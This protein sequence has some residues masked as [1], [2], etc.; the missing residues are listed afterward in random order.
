MDMSTRR[1]LGEADISASLYFWWLAFLRCSRDYWWC[2]QQKG[3]CQDI[4]LVRVWQDFGDIFKYRCFM[5]WWQEHGSKLFDS[6]QMELNLVKHL[7]SGLELLV[8]ADLIRVRPDMVCI[9][10][11]LYLDNEVARAAIW[12]AWEAARV[13]GK[14][15]DKDA[16]YQIFKLDLKGRRTIV[17]AY[18]AWALNSLV[19]RSAGLDALNH[20]GSFEMGRHLNL[21]P[22]NQIRDKDSLED[23][24]RKQNLLRTMF[25]QSKKAAADLIANAEIGQFPCKNQVTKRTRWSQSQENDLAR[26][27]AEGQWQAP[28]WLDGE[29][30]FMLPNG[31][32]RNPLHSA[33]AGLEILENFAR[34]ELS[35]LQPKRTR[36]KRLI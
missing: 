21:S 32:L 35:F 20:W 16:K 14:H 15:Y 22:R 25:C 19:Q 30:A 4:R 26:A 23:R 18:R 17:P 13:R 10:I 27:V 7:A 34:L 24:K 11:P 12:E 31:T 3:Q 29:H 9:A 36:S 5:H 33:S 8:N 1:P 6:P 2:C 28:N